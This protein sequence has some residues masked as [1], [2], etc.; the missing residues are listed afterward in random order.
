MAQSMACVC[1]L[2][3]WPAM[4]GQAAAAVAADGVTPA[5]AAAAA[6]SFQGPGQLQQQQQGQGP[7]AAAVDASTES[8]ALTGIDTS[9]DFEAGLKGVPR[10]EPSSEPSALARLWAGTGATVGQAAA[11]GEPGAAGRPG[12]AAA[13]A[14]SAA[15][16]AALAAAEG[17]CWPQAFL[18]GCAVLIQ[19]S[20]GV[21]PAPSHVP[22]SACGSMS[23]ARSCAVLCWGRAWR[24]VGVPPACSSRYFRLTTLRCLLLA[25][26]CPCVC[27]KW[28]RSCRE[29]PWRCCWC[30]CCSAARPAVQVT[31]AST[32]APAAAGQCRLQRQLGH[33]SRAVGRRVLC[34]ALCCT[35]GRM[36]GRTCSWAWC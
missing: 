3:E 9:R 26:L 31:A 8:L 24:L 1:A 7:A 16:A 34:P 28:H 33:C 20:V 25:L 35:L 5:A 18:T 13:A 30:G 32:A 11:W 14:G 4:A 15:A 36:G 17:V 6:D 12:D 23:L 10:P 29:P 22:R 27:S 2:P 21:G 19:V